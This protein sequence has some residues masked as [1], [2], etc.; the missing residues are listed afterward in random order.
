[1]KEFYV[2]AGNIDIN[3]MVEEVRYYVSLRPNNVGH[4]RFF[5]QYRQGKC[6][7]QPVGINSFG[8]LPK[9]IALF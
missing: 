6:S 4:G 9:R 8:S 3:N 7:R 2:T 5:I 1:M